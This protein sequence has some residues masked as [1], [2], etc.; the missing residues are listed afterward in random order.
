MSGC[1]QA[2]R[3]MYNLLTIYSLWKTWDHNTDILQLFVDLEQSYDNVHRAIVYKN[4]NIGT[5][6]QLINATIT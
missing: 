1:L 2:R 5:G 6:T 3:T 4:V